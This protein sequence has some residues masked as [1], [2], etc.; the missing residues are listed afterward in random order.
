MST[1]PSKQCK[2]LIDILILDNIWRRDFFVEENKNGEEKGG[3]YLEKENI[4]YL[5]EKKNRE[6][7]GMKY[8]E[9]ISPKIVKDIEKCR[10]QSWSQDLCQFFEG[11]GV[12]F[13]EFWFWRILS[14]KNSLGFG[15]GEFCLAK[16]SLGFGFGKFGLEKRVSVWENLV[17]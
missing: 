12:G 3:K 2:S 5:E 9:K 6:G 10:F 7:K 16:K 14:R 13:G 8:L 15:F 4:S 1:R 11:F 17:S